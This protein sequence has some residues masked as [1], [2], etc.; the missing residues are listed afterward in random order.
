MAGRMY[1][2]QFLMR[3]LHNDLAELYEDGKLEERVLRDNL[4]VFMLQNLGIQIGSVS[5]NALRPV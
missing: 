5:M 2:T 4:R 1:D 3:D